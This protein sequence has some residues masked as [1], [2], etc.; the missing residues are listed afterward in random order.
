M[1]E[2]LVDLEKIR[3]LY[4]SNKGFN[5]M[6][7]RY[8]S[9]FPIKESVELAGIVVDIIG[10]GNLQG[11]PKWRF[12]Y[13]SKDKEELNRFG[14]EIKQLF[15][16]DGKIRACTTNPYGES[17][18]YGVNCK[19]LARSLFLAGVPYGEKVMKYFIV[20]NWILQDKE[21]FR[22]FVFRLF[23]CEGTV[24]YSKNSFIELKMN[25]AEHLVDDGILFFQ[26]I[27]DYLFYYFGII[28][29]NIFLGEETTRRKDGLKTVRIR[30]KIKRK[31]KVKKFVKKIGF[32]HENEKI[33]RLLKDENEKALNR[34]TRFSV[35]M[36]S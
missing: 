24:D 6:L 2:I 1:G 22:M 8:K 9:L 32:P 18:L 25:K 31:A 23:C 5:L 3:P 15:Y 11:E 29:N 14:K 21:Y 12:D 13:C 33:I 7:R 4:K 10:D 28:T 16:I 19:P 34:V 36:G 26:M 27:K 20:P 30:L 35:D 17:Y